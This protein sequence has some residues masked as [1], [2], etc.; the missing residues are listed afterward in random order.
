MRLVLK[1][2]RGVCK[3]EEGWSSLVAQR[4]R[5]LALSLLWLRVHTWPAAMAKKKKEKKKKKKEKKGEWQDS[6]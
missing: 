6:G 2:L 5:D 4:V 1:S 3:E